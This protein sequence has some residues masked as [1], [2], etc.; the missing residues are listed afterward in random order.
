MGNAQRTT[1]FKKGNTIGNRF[2]TDN[3]PVRK[4]RKPSLYKKIREITGVTVK[5]EM[6]KDDYYEVIKFLME[7]TPEQLKKM[8]AIG[9]DDGAGGKKTMFDAKVPVWLLNIITA[10]LSDVRYGR[11]STLDSLFDR[12]FG[13][14]TQP[15]EGELSSNLSVSA[16]DISVL[17]TDELLQYN[18][19]LEKIKNGKKE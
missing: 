13:K 2:S 17:S 10:I 12:M 11:T 9:E 3:Q 14:A 7:Q 5:H 6:G 16:P 4:G 18:Q 1:Q 15:I 19:L 8:S